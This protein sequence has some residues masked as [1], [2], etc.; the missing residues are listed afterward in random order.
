MTPRFLTPAPSDPVKSS[1]RNERSMGAPNEDGN[2]T[3]FEKH[4]VAGKIQNLFK[5]P[6]RDE[7][8]IQHGM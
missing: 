4:S 1:E 8:E 3:L 7:T 6:L 2:G 5:V